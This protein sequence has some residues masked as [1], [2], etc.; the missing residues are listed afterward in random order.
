MP[1]YSHA[2]DKVKHRWISLIGVVA[3]VLPLTTGNGAPTLETFTIGIINLTPT[4]DSLIERVKTGMAE[5]GYVEGETVTYI[6]NGIIEGNPQVIDDEIENL[7]AQD[8]DLLFLTGSLAA[9][10]AK[11]AVA[12]TDHPVVFGAV[13]TTI[14]ND[15]VESIQHPGGN[16][17]GIRVGTEI[18]KA[19][20]KQTSPFA[21]I[22]AWRLGLQQGKRHAQ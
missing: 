11:L 8:V 5:S 1:T 6:Y 22:V 2:Q 4:L 19:L 20:D 18:P 10:R 7:L 16:L 14:K 13:N 15:L 3:L 17:T 9:E 21:K 12:G